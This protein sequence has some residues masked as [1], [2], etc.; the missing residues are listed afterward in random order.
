MSMEEEQQRQGTQKDTN[1]PTPMDTDLT[2]EQMLQQAMQ[3]SLEQ[4]V[5]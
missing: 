4:Q 1:E 2:E 3:M 5:F